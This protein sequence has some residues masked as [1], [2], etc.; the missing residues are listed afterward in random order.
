MRL[1]DKTRLEI[2]DAA[3]RFFGADVYLFGSR[4]DDQKRGGDIDLYIERTMS[5]DEAV[6]ARVA[7]LGH[8]YNRIGERKI[9]LVINTGKD[10]RPIF[11]EARRQ[12]QKL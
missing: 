2:R 3:Q 11:D 7:M 8:L 9:D 12:A 1:D 4:T 6:R 5:E 10:D